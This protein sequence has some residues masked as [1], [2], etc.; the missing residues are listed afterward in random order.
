MMN[1]EQETHEEFKESDWKLFRKRVIVWQENYMNRL[2]K[3]YI[4]LLKQDKNPS[5][6]FWELKKE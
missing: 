5:D 1:R 6:I 2:N 3:E 4:T